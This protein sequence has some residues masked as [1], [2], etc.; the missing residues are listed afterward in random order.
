[1]YD[2]SEII[3]K[4]T[5]PYSTVMENKI[6]SGPYDDIEK[7]DE[8]VKETVQILINTKTE[9]KT[10]GDVVNLFWDYS[11]YFFLCHIYTELQSNDLSEE[12]NWLKAKLCNLFILLKKSGIPFNENWVY[13]QYAQVPWRELEKSTK[14]A[15]T[16]EDR[17][18]LRA[19]WFKKA[20]LQKNAM[21]NT[22]PIFGMHTSMKWRCI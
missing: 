15:Q 13:W 22:P 1:M 12:R 2:I 9:L 5:N 19:E 10:I 17:I 20:K 3:W 7:L 16:E 18:K 8:Y 4:M 6:I 11:A 21:Q 14:K